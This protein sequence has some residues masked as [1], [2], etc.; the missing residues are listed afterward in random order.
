MEFVKVLV[1]VRSRGIK[2]MEVSSKN[3]LID[4]EVYLLA[5]KM[6]PHWIGFD[7]E[8]GNVILKDGVE[9]FSMYKY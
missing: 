5:E 3:T 6:F 4:A 1:S 7:E 9:S 8:T 2:E